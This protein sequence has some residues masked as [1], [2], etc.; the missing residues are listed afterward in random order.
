MCC[1]QLLCARHLVVGSGAF[2]KN[3]TAP[4]QVNGMPTDMLTC[5]IYRHIAEKENFK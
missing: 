5:S 2:L 3:V 1:G 4:R